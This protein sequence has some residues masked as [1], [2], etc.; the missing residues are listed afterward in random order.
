[1]AACWR[2]AKTDHSKNGD[3]TKELACMREALRPVRKLFGD[4]SAQHFGPN[5]LKALRQE[6]IDSDLT[7]GLINRRP[8]VRFQLPQ[9]AD[10]SHPAG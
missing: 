2:F 7:R 10:G 6:M 1:M 5:A 3:P 8:L 9:L 4:T